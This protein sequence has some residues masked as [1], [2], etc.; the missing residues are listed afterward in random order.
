MRATR[1]IGWAG[2]LVGGLGSACVGDDGPAAQDTTGVATGDAGTAEA[3]AGTAEATAGTADTVDTAADTGTGE[4]PPAWGPSLD[5]DQAVGAFFSVWGPEPSLVYAVAGQPTGGGLSEGALYRFDGARWSPQP[6]PAGIPALNWVFGVGSR[7]VLV[8]DFGVIL[9][10]DGDEGEWTQHGCG[11]IL[12]LWGV[13]GAAA[14]D[15][16][17]VG[18]DGFH[19]DPVACHFDGITWTLVEL[20]E[21]SMESHALYKIW[22]TAADDVWAV[23]DEGLLMHY[24]GELEGWTELPSGTEFDL[25]SVWG[26]GPD[27][28]LAVG[29]RTTGVLSR[30]DG[31][32][33]TAVEVP[34]LAGLNG[35]WMAPDG[36]ATVVG[37]QGG[38]GVVATGAMTVELEDSGTPLALHG[39]FGFPAVAR[40]AVGG[41]LDMAPPHVGVILHRAP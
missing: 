40:W 30:F 2:V 35:V 29:G 17:A 15:V 14:D 19:R 32:Q 21:P 25:I 38:A 33:W 28:V 4:P 16:W 13:W 3:T 22:G 18:G 11:T 31:A 20:P 24:G 34:A 8:G 1:G 36:T 12:P 6:L 10:R 23:G 7:R 37:P 41:S 26:T 27:E 39:V 5:V 9:V